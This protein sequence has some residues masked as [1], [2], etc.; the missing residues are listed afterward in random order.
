[1]GIVLRARCATPVPLRWRVST[2]PDVS[3][4]ALNSR[5]AVTMLVYCRV[6]RID[7]RSLHFVPIDRIQP[8]RTQER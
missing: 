7:L 6:H 2:P 8:S 3:S 4:K 1:M 5:R